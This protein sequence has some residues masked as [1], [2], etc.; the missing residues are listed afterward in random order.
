MKKYTLALLLVSPTTQVWADSV[1]NSFSTSIS[2]IV[3]LSAKDL[4]ERFKLKAEVF[5]TDSNGK[6]LKQ[7]NV[8]SY[9][10]FGKTG[11]LIANWN[12]S[13]TDAKFNV[14]LIWKLAADATIN[15]EIEQFDSMKRKEGTREVILGKSLKKDKGVLKN[16]SNIVWVA[17]ELKNK[18]VILRLTPELD[19]NDSFISMQEF[20]LSLNN[21]IIYDNKGQVWGREIDI[22]SRYIGITTHRGRVALSFFPFK[23]AKEIGIVRG[24]QIVIEAPKDDKIYIQTNTPILNSK[25]SAKIYG[26]VDYKKRTDRIHSVQSS[27][28]GEEKEFL[29]RLD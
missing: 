9:W 17:Q 3:D 5:V 27:S 28:S 18:K 15:Y 2:N 23:G 8:L 13:S 7:D 24:S 22:E 16:F 4:R 12:Y 25:K 21:A 26:F 20:P 14:R 1:N 19:E 11:D 29:S 10:K 6:L